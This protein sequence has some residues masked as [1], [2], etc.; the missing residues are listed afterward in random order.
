FLGQFERAIEEGLEAVRRNPSHGYPYSNLSQ[1]YRGIGRFDDA[2]E[3]AERAGALNIETLPTRCLLYQVAVLA[4]DKAAETRHVA[5]GRDGPREFDLVAARAE[6]AAHSGKIRVARDLYEEAAR[7]A[8]LRNLA[9]VGTSH[10]A[11]ATWMEWAYGN[12]DAALREARR[13]L[14]RN[15]NYDARLRVALTL[16]MPGAASD[17]AAIACEMSRT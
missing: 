11:W 2:R 12:E 14:A 1:A 4:C 13:V 3:F 8:E 15:P 7:M 10:L 6:V 5:W 9:N 17:A 16:S